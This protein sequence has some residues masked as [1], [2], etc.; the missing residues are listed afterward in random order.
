[1]HSSYSDCITSRGGGS[2]GRRGEKVIERNNVIPPFK[3]TIYS[4]RHLLSPQ[5][6][7]FGL[8]QWLSALRSRRIR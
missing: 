1:M 5:A 3:C 8:D 2:G 6:H 7:R 4:G